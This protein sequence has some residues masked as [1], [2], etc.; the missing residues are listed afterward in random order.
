MK[1]KKNASREK[2]E[3]PAETAAPAPENIAT[4]SELKTF[5]LSI[6]DRMK[7]QT[8]APVY[9]LSAMQYIFGLQE[10]N[11]LL[12]ADN[13]EIARD[14]WLRLKQAGIQLKSPPLLF[15]EDAPAK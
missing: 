10:L 2:P 7:G 5:L 9:V 11:S 15:T 13:R 3:A 4:A 6:R 8:S 14:I 12:D 1:E